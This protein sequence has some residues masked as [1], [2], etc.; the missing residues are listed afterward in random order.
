MISQ[1]L[2]DRMVSIATQRIYG[3]GP[4]TTSQRNGVEAAIMAALRIYEESKK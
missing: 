4:H 3:G 2:V 1:N